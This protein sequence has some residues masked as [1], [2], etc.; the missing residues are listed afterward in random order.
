MAAARRA[1]RLRAPVM[2]SAPGTADTTSSR[3]LIPGELVFAL[4]LVV[5]SGVG[6]LLLGQ[7]ANIDLYRYRLYI[8]Y[9]FV[10]GRLDQDLAPSALGT[11]PEPRARRL[12]LPR[13]RAPAAARL[14]LPAGEPSGPELRPG[15]LARS[16]GAP[17]GSDLA[18]GRVPRRTARGLGPDR[19][20]APR[21]NTR[22][23]HR[24]PAGARSAPARGHGARP[25]ERRPARMAPLRRGRAGRRRRRPQADDGH[26]LRLVARIP[27]VGP[28]AQTHR[29]GG[30]SLARPLGRLSA[31]WPSPAAGASRCGSGSRILCSRS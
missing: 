14:Q 18:A 12:P 23:H 6:A 7:D 30:R 13:H 17:R 28:R 5:G 29:H 20:L 19:P 25:T 8:G 22:R 27:R 16:R 2:A 3:I 11:L 10:H 9:A 26:G 1:R 4:L 31:T 21:H 15:S 24:L